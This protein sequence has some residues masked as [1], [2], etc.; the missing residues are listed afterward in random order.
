VNSI[1]RRLIFS[2]T[3]MWLPAPVISSTDPGFLVLFSSQFHSTR[4][5]QIERMHQHYARHLLRHK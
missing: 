1:C 2:A 5:V 4:H 3:A